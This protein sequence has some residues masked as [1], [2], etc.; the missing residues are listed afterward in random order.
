M[1]LLY[2]RP[3]STYLNTITTTY[4]DDDEA[5]LNYYI[6]FAPDNYFLPRADP[7]SHDLIVLAEN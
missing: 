3:T 4:H 6:H 2:T 1:R 5:T 7:E